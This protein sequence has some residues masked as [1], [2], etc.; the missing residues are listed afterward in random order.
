MRSA[1]VKEL[2][3][4]AHTAHGAHNFKT[5]S[6]DNSIEISEED[7]RIAWEAYIAHD[8][9][10]ESQFHGNL[11]TKVNEMVLEE[12]LVLV[13]EDEEDSAEKPL[14]SDEGFLAHQEAL[15]A[16]QG[17]KDEQLAESSARSFRN[18]ALEKTDWLVGGDSP[19]SE[20]EVDQIK[21]WRVELR[22]APMSENW[23]QL[24]PPPD[25]KTTKELFLKSGGYISSPTNLNT[26]LTQLPKPDE[27]DDASYGGEVIK[28]D[29]LM[30]DQDQD[31]PLAI[32]RQKKLEERKKIKIASDEE[33]DGYVKGEDGGWYLKSASEILKNDDAE[34][35]S[36]PK[37]A[38]DES[39][40]FVKDDPSTPDHNEAWEG[41]KAPESESDPESSEE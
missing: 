36:E 29:E 23:P 7:R 21:T 9:T 2:A 22:E 20:D 10:A 17:K 18:M 33:T 35:D 4:K 30:K 41:G 5:M 24:P 32:V 19:L 26:P 25:I 11:P 37:R 3:R 6:I 34:L 12:D 16:I 13:D 39:G 15:L 28:F 31:V 14:P 38:R 8:P 1:E 27:R 40:K